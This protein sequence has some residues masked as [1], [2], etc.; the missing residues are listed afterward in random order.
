MRV[1]GPDAR[2]A[3]YRIELEH[4]LTRGHEDAL[5][6]GSGAIATS[7]INSRVWLRDGGGFA[8]HLIDP[9]TGKPA[10]TG[11]ISVTALAPT[12][13]EAETLAKTAF[14]MGPRG[15]R[16]TLRARGGA[17]VHDDGRVERVG[18]CWHGPLLHLR[19]SPPAGVAA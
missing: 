1:G 19:V 14:L 9:A 5:S 6:L 16:Q 15:A 12:A 17:I 18:S 8:H 4:P 2:S 13:L 10:W 7:G 11:L 3:P